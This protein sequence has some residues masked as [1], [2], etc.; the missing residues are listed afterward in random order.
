MKYKYNWEYWI[1][2]D[3]RTKQAKQFKKHLPRWKVYYIKE[4][5]KKYKRRIRYYAD[6]IKSK[7]Y[8]KQPEFVKEAAK[9]LKYKKIGPGGGRGPGAGWQI[10]GGEGNLTNL[11]DS[12]YNFR[13]NK[14]LKT[15]SIP[16]LGI[17]KMS[18][19]EFN[20]KSVE[21]RQDFEDAIG[22]LHS[23]IEYPELGLIIE[24]K[25]NEITGELV[26]NVQ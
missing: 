1:D 4:K 16:I 3:F 15:I 21:I 26:L 9:E 25:F 12:F 5:R 24:Y 10:M 17:N 22:N 2:L 20:K 7:K 8:K 23:E 19:K 18:K 11:I 13:Q 14:K 6:N